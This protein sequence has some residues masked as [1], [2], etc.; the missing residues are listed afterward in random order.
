[1]PQSVKLPTLPAFVPTYMLPGV[2][3][4]GHKPLK[5]A[6]A[7]K[8]ARYTGYILL[9]RQQIQAWT[10]LAFQ[11]PEKWSRELYAV[12]TA[13]KRRK[14]FKVCW[15][16]A[17]A[18]SD[19]ASVDSWPA[20]LDDLRVANYTVSWSSSRQHGITRLLVYLEF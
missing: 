16:K 14:R 12:G 10:L 17:D 20:L 19:V 18:F 5:S 15:P 6:S 13:G 11:N 1:M 7:E 4:V 8:Q 2:A 3:V 9:L